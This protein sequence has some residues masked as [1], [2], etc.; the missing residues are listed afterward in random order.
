AYGMVH[1]EEL[2]ERGPAEL[3]LVADGDSEAWLA[4]RCDGASEVGWGRDVV[5]VVRLRQGQ[6]HNELPTSGCLR[7]WREPGLGHL[8]VSNYI[9]STLINQGPGCK[10]S[11]ALCV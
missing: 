5:R 2:F 7:R 1:F 3:D 11:H 8:H 9:M 4:R 10:K 6:S